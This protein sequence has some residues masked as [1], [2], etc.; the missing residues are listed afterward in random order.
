MEE[1]EVKHF[2]SIRQFYLDAYKL[3]YQ[4]VHFQTD[5]LAA[6]F[7]LVGVAIVAY[8]LN[9]IPIF[10]LNFN[11][12][13]ILIIPTAIGFLMLIIAYLFSNFYTAKVNAETSILLRSEY[14]EEMDNF[15]ILDGITNRTKS[16]I[17]AYG[18][19]LKL[20]RF[21]YAISISLSSINCM[22]IK[23][24]LYCRSVCFSAFIFGMQFVYAVLI[25]ALYINN[26]KTLK[27]MLSK[28]P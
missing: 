7:S 20:L 4:L 22:Y 11:Q 15:E 9:N 8:L 14:S 13:I 3:N 23:Y 25:T 19:I 28:K 2:D 27:S 21:G 17:K 6:F 5:K 24:N 26:N 18:P 12:A 10:I 16:I 1:K